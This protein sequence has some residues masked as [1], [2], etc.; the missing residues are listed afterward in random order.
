MRRNFKMELFFI[1]L[2]MAVVLVI[3]TV[4]TKGENKNG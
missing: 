1:V 3:D 4:V 2:L